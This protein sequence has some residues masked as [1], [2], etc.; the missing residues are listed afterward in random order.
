MF[1][2]LGTVLVLWGAIELFTFILV[3]VAVIAS[4]VRVKKRRNNS[5]TQ[6]WEFLY[7][8]FVV[9]VVLFALSSW[10]PWEWFGLWD[11]SGGPINQYA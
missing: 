9:C 7:W 8:S 3:A 10:T 1:G 2:P 4:I 5:T 6:L 11:G